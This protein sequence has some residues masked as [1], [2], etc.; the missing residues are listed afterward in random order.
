MGISVQSTRDGV[1]FIINVNTIQQCLF[2][3]EWIFSGHPMALSFIQKF[4]PVMLL[5]SK[6]SLLTSVLKKKHIKVDKHL[7]TTQKTYMLEQIINGSELTCLV[8]FC[9]KIKKMYN[10]QNL[11]RKEFHKEMIYSVFFKMKREIDSS[12]DIQ[13]TRIKL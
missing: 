6:P 4:S 2:Q 1:Y 11:Y 12:L 3:Q 10:Y 7:C 13:L 5:L 8:Y 9:L